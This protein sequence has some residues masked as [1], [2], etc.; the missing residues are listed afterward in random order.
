M[1]VTNE[2]LKNYT[3]GKVSSVD[4]MNNDGIEVKKASFYFGIKSIMYYL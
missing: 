1:T 3:R 2:I 4:E